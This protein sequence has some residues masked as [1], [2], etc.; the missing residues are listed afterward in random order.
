MAVRRFLNCSQR[1]ASSYPS[2]TCSPTCVLRG[3]KVGSGSWRNHDRCRSSLSYGGPG[4]CENLGWFTRLSS[5]PTATNCGPLRAVEEHWILGPCR[6]CWTPSFTMNVPARDADAE[7]SS[8]LPLLWWVRVVLG[9]PW[10][11]P[12]LWGTG[13]C[14]AKFIFLYTLSSGSMRP[15]DC[16]WCHGEWQRALCLDAAGEAAIWDLEKAGR[17]HG[18]CFWSATAMPSRTMRMRCQPVDMRWQRS[19]LQPA[20]RQKRDF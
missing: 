4:S 9:C 13:G 6:W 14:R 2:A 17:V 11:C 12:G 18:T 15:C 16:C 1:R 8:A 20:R 7:W 5:E 3:G 10:G 19:R